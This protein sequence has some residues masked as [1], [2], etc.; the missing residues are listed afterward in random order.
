MNT[1]S[2]SYRGYE[3]SWVEPPLTSAGWTVNVAS[4]DRAL[5][6]LMRQPGSEVITRPTRDAAVA[7]AKIYIDGLLSRSS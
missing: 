7:A 3:I 5:Y 4:E 6:A 2:E 1:K